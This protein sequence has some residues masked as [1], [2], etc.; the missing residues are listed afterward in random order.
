MARAYEMGWSRTRLTA[1]RQRPRRPEK[2]MRG[3]S[4]ETVRR[5][6][7]I[8]AGGEPVWPKEVAASDDADDE[9]SVPAAEVAL[10]AAA[11]AEALDGSPL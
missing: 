7:M 11:E 6:S 1:P 9:A 10:E 5:R 3:E 2:S 4:A 8:R